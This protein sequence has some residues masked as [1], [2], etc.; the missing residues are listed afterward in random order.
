[1]A[2]E[3]QQEKFSSQLKN[4]Y[5]QQ[6]K[7][8]IIHDIGCMPDDMNNRLFVCYSDGD[9]NTDFL[10]AIKMGGLNIRLMSAIQIMDSITEY[11]RLS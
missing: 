11:N 5:I 4:S 10:S 3:K 6:A 7:K 8:S 9:L 1:M 2:L